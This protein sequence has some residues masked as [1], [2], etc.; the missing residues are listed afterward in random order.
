MAGSGTVLAA[1]RATGR[2]CIALD[3]DP[4]A[5]LAQRVLASE[6]DVNQVERAGKAALAKA[7]E[8]SRDS[9]R[10]D[11]RLSDTF[12]AETLD[13]IKLWFPARSRRRLFSLWS[14][15]SNATPARARQPL[16]IAFSKL[17]IAKTAGVSRAI[18]LPHT[19]PHRKPGKRI[20][21][22][23]EMFPRRLS[24]VL[25]TLARHH[26]TPVRGPLVV[27]RADARS[28]PIQTASVDLVLTSSPYANAIDYIRAHKF[29]L[30]WMGYSLSELRTTRAQ[31]IG[32]ERGERAARR[33]LQWVEAHLPTAS[34]RRR[35]IIRKYFY[36]M[37]TS[38]REMHRVLKP[39]GGCVLILGRSRVGDL[40]IDNPTVAARL[41]ENCGFRHIG[42][43]YRKLNPLRRS[44]PF[45]PKKQNNALGKRMAEEAVVALG[46]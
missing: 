29:S 4:L 8:E 40:V 28:L 21:D 30:V 17:I 3:L 27:R 41:A 36:D 22:V 10:I 34:S 20:P 43:L 12:D 5:S 7:I 38:L 23:F 24:E 37:D 9:K 11:R 14:A 2:R 31:L 35:D 42:T 25:T 1:A 19:R 33:D 6:Q 13:F 44:L 32:A 46:R 26:A 45:P 18:D 39:G 15:I 16:A